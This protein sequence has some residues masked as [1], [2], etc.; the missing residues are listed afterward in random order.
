MIVVEKKTNEKENIPL[1]EKFSAAGGIKGHG[2]KEISFRKHIFSKTTVSTRF[3]GYF[4]PLLFLY[5]KKI[6][7]YDGKITYFF[8]FL[9]IFVY[10]VKIYHPYNKWGNK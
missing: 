1:K 6:S 4:I 2:H 5:L 10:L 3:S 8:F 9:N 7:R